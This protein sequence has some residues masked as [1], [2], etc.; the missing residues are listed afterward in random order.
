MSE[1]FTRREFLQ[2]A[3]I[4]MGALAVST[5]GVDRLLPPLPSPSIPLASPPVMSLLLDLAPL[6]SEL[7]S[8]QEKKTLV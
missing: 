8:Q 4:T 2:S 6:A 3:C 5:S 1:Q 7:L